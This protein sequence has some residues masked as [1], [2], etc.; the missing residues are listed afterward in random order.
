M[1]NANLVTINTFAKGED[2]TVQYIYKLIDQGE[3]KPEII[4][5]VRF[6][7]KSQYNSVKKR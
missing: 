4:D 7:D 6:I 5:G 1:T 3:I 2:C